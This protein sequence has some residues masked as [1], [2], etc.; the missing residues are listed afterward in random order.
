MGRS[1]FRAFAQT[2]SKK[3]YPKKITE[4]ANA[5]KNYSEETRKHTET[6]RKNIEQYRKFNEDIKKYD[7]VKT[8]CIPSIPILKTPAANTIPKEQTEDSTVSK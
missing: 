8:E 6:I 3:Q 2:H 4:I 1:L 7:R 5:V